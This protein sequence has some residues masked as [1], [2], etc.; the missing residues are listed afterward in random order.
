MAVGGSFDPYVKAALH[1]RLFG[2]GVIHS[3]S[4]RPFS[5]TKS[6]LRIETSPWTPASTSTTAM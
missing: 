4:F 2:K 6:N 1:E 5:S 3:S